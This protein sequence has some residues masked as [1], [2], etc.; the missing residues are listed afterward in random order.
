MPPCC[1]ATTTNSRPWVLRWKP[2]VPGVSDPQMAEEE[3]EDVLEAGAGVR[4]EWVEHRV[5]AA[6]RRVGHREEGAASH[7]VAGEGDAAAP[8]QDDNP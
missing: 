2:F 1:L 7:L 5:E 4:E 3:E 6:G 8:P